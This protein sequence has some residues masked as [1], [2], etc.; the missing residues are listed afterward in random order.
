MLEKQ[1]LQ[2]ILVCDDGF[3]QA[4]QLVFT[5]TFILPKCLCGPKSYLMSFLQT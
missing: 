2:S 1:L 5:M 3:C 4:S